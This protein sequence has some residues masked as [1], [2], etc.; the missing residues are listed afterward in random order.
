MPVIRY[1]CSKCDHEF[2]L[3]RPQS[4]AS[5]Y[6]SCP[7]CNHQAS[8]SSSFQA[9][10][11]AGRQEIPTAPARG[12]EL[13]HWV[14]GQVE[15]QIRQMVRGGDA[16]GG[17]EVDIITEKVMRELGASSLEVTPGNIKL[18]AQKHIAGLDSWAK[19]ARRTGAQMDAAAKLDDEE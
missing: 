16:I 15:A 5:E 13:P 11:P 14:R 18:L 19:T 1:H 8:P 3:M 7:K 10:A 4:K 6:M 9:G 2:E 12:R 17:Q